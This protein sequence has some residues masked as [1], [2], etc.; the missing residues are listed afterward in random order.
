MTIR[1]SELLLAV[2]FADRIPV[3]AKL[4]L[5]FRPALRPTQL[6]VHWVQVLFL[7]DK[8]VEAWR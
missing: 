2:R 7:G 5:P 8:A 6:P 1:Y 3:R 4:S